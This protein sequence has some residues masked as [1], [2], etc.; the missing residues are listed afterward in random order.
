[1]A[2]LYD[3]FEKRFTGLWFSAGWQD[4]EPTGIAQKK[5]ETNTRKSVELLQ[6]ELDDLQENMERI[7]AKGL[8]LENL[9]KF[10]ND[11]I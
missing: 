2:N 10:Y 7:C 9:A 3:E 11:E 6:K 5:G 8:M 1:M 4:V